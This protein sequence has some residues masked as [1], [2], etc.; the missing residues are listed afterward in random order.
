M[1]TRY[2]IFGPCVGILALC[3][4]AGCAHQ[5]PDRP[6]GGRGVTPPANPVRAMVRGATENV[7]PARLRADIDRL[8][9]FGT[10]HT[11]SDRASDTRGVGAAARWIKSEFDKAAADRARLGLPAMHVSLEPH[12]LEPDGRRIDAPVE[13]QNVVAV[14]PGRL[15]A[16]GQAE[17]IYISGHYDSRNGNEMDRT[18]DAPGANDDASGTAVAIELC[19]VLATREFDHTLVFVAFDAEEA[20]LYGSR[21]HVEQAVAENARIRAV[22]NNDIVGDPTSP[23]GRETRTLIR[24]FS[25]GLQ[26][27]PIGGDSIGGRPGSGA[28]ATIERLRREGALGDSSSRQLARY[29]YETA[30]Q[31]R[32]DVRPIIIFRADRFLRGGDHTPFHDAGYPAVRFTEVHEDYNRQHQDVKVESGV[33]FGDEP[34]FV[35]ANYLAGVARLNAAAAVCLAS[36]PTAPADARII[37]AALDNTT[38]LRWSRSPDP[39]TAGYEIVWRETTSPVWNYVMDA[40]NATEATINISKDNVFF[41]VRAYDREGYRSLVSFAYAARE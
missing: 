2:Q 3:A 6:L 14:I 36:A 5:H 32:T 34:Q 39:D 29:V 18:G 11:M 30:W 7:S 23:D 21:K 22:L 38:T 12:T 40:R 41:G 15:E 20:G 17:R 24:L 19:R 33:R 31:H 9:S 35:D 10:R 4:L 8:V 26:A 1:P 37:T 27:G 16:S 28:G 25:E 13:I